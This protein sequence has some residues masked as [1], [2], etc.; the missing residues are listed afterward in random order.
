MPPA[1]DAIVVAKPVKESVANSVNGTRKPHLRFT[2]NIVGPII[3]ATDLACLAASVP[4]ALIA[5]DI[6]IG[7]GVIY[8]VHIFALA[9]LAA[10]FI[11]IRSS[12]RAWST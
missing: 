5:Y 11:L 1:D 10:S 2:S 3:L 12:R 9:I 6:L 4:M 7:E 8:S